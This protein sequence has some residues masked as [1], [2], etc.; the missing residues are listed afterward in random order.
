MKNPN[1]AFLARPL[2]LINSRSGTAL[3][4]S[5]DECWPAGAR[6]FRIARGR[7][8]GA[9]RGSGRIGA[10]LQQ[11]SAGPT[12]RADHRRWRRHGGGGCG[13][14]A[15]SRHSAGN[16]AAGNLQSRGARSSDAAGVGRRVD[17]LAGGEIREIDL[18]VVNGRPFL[19]VCIL[20]FYPEQGNPGE[21]RRG[22]PWWVK[23]Y[24]YLLTTWR[25]FST[26]PRL[27][28]TIKADIGDPA[29]AQPFHRRFEQC[30][31]RHGRRDAEEIQSGWRVAGR[32]RLR[33]PHPGR[34]GGG[35]HGLSVRK[36]GGRPRHA[37]DAGRQVEI[38][39]ARRRVAVMV[40]GEVVKETTPLR[41]SIES[42][43]GP[44]DRAGG[45]QDIMTTLAHLSDLHFGR[46]DPRVAESL[47]EELHERQPD[48]IVVS[49]DFTQRARRREFE[50][51]RA[52]VERFPSRPLM[53]PGKS[54]RGELPP[55]AGALH[56]AGGEIS[57]LSWR[58]ICFRGWKEEDVS[59]LGINSARPAGWYLDWSR[60]RI[61]ARQL[62]EID[63]PFPRAEGRQ[64]EDPRH[65]SSVRFPARSG[66][67]P[68][69]EGAERHAAAAGFVRSGPDPRRPFPPRL[70]RCGGDAASGGEIHRG[71]PGVH[72]HLHQAEGGTERLQLDRNRFA[73]V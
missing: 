60:G 68:S 46:L 66:H 69:R 16:P 42:P 57:A 48:L 25:S 2:V 10:A 27:A 41:F 1:L 14:G 21:E 32:L 24:L 56:E 52:Y 50:A 29:G 67:P 64:G 17:A 51:A 40:D 28:F 55:G 36:T 23:A 54:R 70:E 19:C 7:C 71:G 37:Y 33:P 73:R 31:S 49:G 58:R 3:R 59:V 13:G 43:G 53:V 11:I 30:V 4:L 9:L 47:L 39:C 44:G 20:G 62:E 72:V 61:S 45:I 63:G 5:P 6:A 65:A 18:G 8:G 34:S 15:G 26:Y 12:E 35:Q 38:A 22:S